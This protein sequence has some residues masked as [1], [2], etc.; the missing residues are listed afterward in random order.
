MSV[1]L[2]HLALQYRPGDEA[3]ARHLLEL[4][5]CTLVDNGPAPGRDGFCSVLL[6]SADD[7]EA[8]AEDLLFLAPATEAQLALE[9]RLGELG[10]TLDLYWRVREEKPES[11]AHLGIRFRSLD[12]LVPVVEGLTAATNPGGALEGRASLTVLRAR[13]GLD[14]EVD[15]RLD[16]SPW[17][18]DAP[19]SYAPH[20]IQCFVRT[21]LFGVG[22]VG[23]GFTVELDVVFPRFFDAPPSFGRVTSTNGPDAPWSG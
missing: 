15:A 5:G 10:E 17:F 7:R 12:D 3:G 11:F 18:A 4:L 23:L 13:T 21:D 1:S 14:P 19:P 9:D 20:W 22:L 6:R 8:Y 16:A 2:G